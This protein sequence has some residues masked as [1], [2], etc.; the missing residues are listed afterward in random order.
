M[1]R[2]AATIDVD[3]TVDC[4]HGGTA[5][6]SLHLDLDDLFQGPAVGNTGSFAF[7]AC[8]RADSDAADG[9]VTLGG[10]V[11][12]TVTGAS[13]GLSAGDYDLT[14]GYTRSTGSGWP[15]PPAPASR[16]TAPSR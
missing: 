2:A 16:P 9:A 13:G 4:S 11:G 6:V 15:S 10:R 1:A 5:Q 14:Y 7:D 8:T 12:Y 3:R